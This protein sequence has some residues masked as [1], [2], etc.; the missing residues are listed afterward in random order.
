M[1]NEIDI[2]RDVSEKLTSASIAFM[3]TGSVALSYYATPRMTRDID[4]VMAVDRGHT[5]KI[6]NLFGTDYY[7]SAEAVTDAVQRKS[8]FNII[9]FDSV[10]KVDFIVLKDTPFAMAAFERRRELVLGSF[11]TTIISREDLILSKLDW[12]KDSGSEM[13]L[14]DVRSLLAASCDL[15]YLRHWA[16]DLSLNET[17]E[18]LLKVS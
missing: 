12:A 3:L 9:H 8:M 17:L 18:S 2:L 7:V 4:I 15:E 1:Q 6:S 5:E 13:Q 11:Q 16:E 10:I 14:R